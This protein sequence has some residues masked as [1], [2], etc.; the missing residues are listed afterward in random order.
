MTNQA[1]QLIGVAKERA[2]TVAAVSWVIEGCTISALGSMPI[3][4]PDPREEHA[5]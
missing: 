1:I 3:V 4:Q 5:V 2:L